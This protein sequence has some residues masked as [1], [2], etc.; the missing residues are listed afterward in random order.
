MRRV[1]PPSRSLLDDLVRDALDPA[2]LTAAARRAAPIGA[3][4]DGA[5]LDSAGPGGAGPGGAGAG[6]PASRR[7]RGWLVWLVLAVAGAGTAAAVHRQAVR[8]PQASRV[9]AALIADIHD[10]TA[11]DDALAARIAQLRAAT[12]KQR[13]ASL[14]RSE[15]GAALTA[16]IAALEAAVGSAAARGPGVTLRLSDATAAVSTP[17]G[18][19]PSNGGAAPGDILAPESG[20]ILDRDVA[21]AVNALWAAGARAVAVGGVRLTSTTAIRTAGDTILAGFTPLQSPYD[22]VAL[23][24][25]GRLATDTANSAAGRRLTGYRGAYGIG[26]S[27]LPG[28]ALTVPAAPVT[29]PRLARE[30]DR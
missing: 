8:A 6:P 26:F 21:D 17:P 14:A 20:R 12:A 19:G 24:D 22:I 28:A 30:S 2:Y 5:G 23:G 16:R 4:P 18:L 10:R 1:S 7:R 27:I 13:A 25:P 9:R 15:Q 29:T 3:G 11:A